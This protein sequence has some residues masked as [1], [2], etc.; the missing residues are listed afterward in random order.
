MTSPA[1]QH[2][3]RKLAARAAASVDNPY[4]HATGYE[5]ML[6]QLTEHRRQLHDIQSIE[7]KAEL[8]RK[9]LPEYS[10]YL[11]GVMEGGTG[12][13]DDVFMTAL[14]WS[15]DVGAFPEALQLA[16]YAIAHGMKLP[17]QYKRTTA[18][19]IAEEFAEQAI[20]AKDGQSAI[21]VASLQEVQELT[22]DQDMPDEVRAKLWKAIGYG[23]SAAVPDESKEAAA[24]RLTL[25]L[26]ALQRALSLHDKAGVKKDI[27]RLQRELK[28]TAEAQGNGGNPA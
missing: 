18:C 11:L 6:V 28:N 26:E 12:Q 1:K 17:D 3:Q 23:L 10:A 14:V 13:Q 24:T 20:K 15:I 21:D 7:R 16:E 22:A 4:R 2:M 5:L 19:L 27:E 8:K 9:I 25:A